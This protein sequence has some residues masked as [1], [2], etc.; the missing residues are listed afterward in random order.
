[1]SHV[2]NV[3]LAFSILE[4]SIELDDPSEPEMWTIMDTINAWLRDNCR[5]Q[6]FGPDVSSVGAAYGGNKVLE[7]PLFIAAFNY[8]PESEFIAFLHTLP[9]EHPDEVQVLVKRQ[10]DDF[11]EI[12][13]LGS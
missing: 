12:V 7:T 3:I 13:A 9:W 4:D 1:M 8:L 11:F 10:H 6:E 5:G 2:D